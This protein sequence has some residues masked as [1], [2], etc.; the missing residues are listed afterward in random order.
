MTLTVPNAALAGVMLNTSFAIFTAS[1]AAFNKERAVSGRFG[2]CDVVAMVETRGGWGKRRGANAVR[3]LGP[4]TWTSGNFVGHAF[5]AHLTRPG[6]ATC[7]FSHSEPID[8]GSCSIDRPVLHGPEVTKITNPLIR[9]WMLAPMGWLD[10]ATIGLSGDLEGPTPAAKLG[11]GA[12]VITKS[13]IGVQN[14]SSSLLVLRPL[15]VWPQ[16]LLYGRSAGEFT[17]GF[18]SFVTT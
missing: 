1:I 14:S 4:I 8:E 7:E 18:V 16:P 5:D 6:H 9:R 15:N 12:S 11:L 3:G 10:G 17:V 2:R 13:R